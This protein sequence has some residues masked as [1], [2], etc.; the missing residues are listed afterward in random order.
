MDNKKLKCDDPELL[1]K[2]GRCYKKLLLLAN[3]KGKDPFPA[4]DSCPT[5]Y[6]MMLHNRI[7]GEKTFPDDLREEITDMLSL[8]DPDD[9]AASEGKILPMEKRIYFHRGMVLSR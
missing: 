9:W 5:K 8:V 1:E 4:S 2:I 3:E 6:F 7:I